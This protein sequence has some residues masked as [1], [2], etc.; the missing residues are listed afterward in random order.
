VF[1]IGSPNGLFF[2]LRGAQLI[3]R[4][5]AGDAKDDD[6]SD[7]QVCGARLFACVC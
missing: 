5:N 4:R 7:A 3:A 2:H 6:A 1:F